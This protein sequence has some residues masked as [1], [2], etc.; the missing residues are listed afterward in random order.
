MTTI[1][2]IGQGSPEWHEHRRKYRNAS[3]TPVVMGVSPWTTPYQLWQLKLG[4]IEQEVTPAMRHGSELEPV[5]RAAYERQTGRIMQPLVV[6]DGEYSASLDGMTL[7]GE[8]IVEIKSPVK[9]RD[10]TLWQTVDAGRLPEHYHLQVQHQ[11]LVTG[12]AVVDVFVFDGTE[13]VLLEVSPE[14][15]TWPRI[16]TAWEEFVGFVAKG[17]PPPLTER[18][19]RHRD[20]P[21]WLEAAAAY[22][23]LK[24]A[25]DE[26][27]IRLEEAKK[28]LVQ[29]AG[30]AREVGG[31]IA[32]TKCWRRDCVDYE[33]IP[34]LAGVD[35]DAYRGPRHSEFRVTVVS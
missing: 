11:L 15:N 10:S 34:E 13:G 7:G 18:D 31:G 32:V 24:G 16:H 35:L 27:S 23:G 20:D 5:A 19:V 17:E 6:I 28:T 29:L 9:G 21:E 22:L 3:E 25:S 33:R 2:R 1:V 8:R 30:H 14:P 12:A 26:L 4:L